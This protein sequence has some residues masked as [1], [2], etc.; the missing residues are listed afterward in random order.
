[1]NRILLMLLSCLSAIACNISDSEDELIVFPKTE[2]IAVSW[3]V[4]DDALEDDDRRTSQFSIQVNGDQSLPS[5]GWSLYFNQFPHAIYLSPSQEKLFQVENINGDLYR[6]LPSDSFPRVESGEVVQLGYKSHWPLVKK[7][8]GP[9]GVFFVVQ[10]GTP[11]ERVVSVINFEILPFPSQITYSTSRGKIPVHHSADIRYDMNQG[12]SD[13]PLA[14]VNRIVPTPFRSRS[15]GTVVNVKS[16]MKI[17]F[18]QGLEREADHLATF[19][20]QVLQD[21]ISS[22]DSETKDTGV[23]YL[24]QSSLT[25][26]G[27]SEEAYRLILHPSTGIEI[28]G[29]DPSGVFYGIQTFKA[30]LPVDAFKEPA[31]SIDVPAMTIEDIPRFGY[32]GLH[33]DI[34]RNFQDY[35]QIRKVIQLMAFYKLNRLHLHLTDDEGWRL[36]IPGLPEL[37]EVGSRRGWSTKESPVLPPAYGSGAIVDGEE[38]SGSGHLSREQFIQLLR[39]ANDHH[40]QIIPEING[41]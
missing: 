27:K 15:T 24:R 31:A 25:I 33:L 26:D 29:A 1:M 40:I 10:E 30:L 3:K 39:Y 16:N 37:T 21:P 6:I 17:L 23:I 11:H 19:L 41:P 12:I 18:D 20:N 14:K 2:Q 9:K 4:I 36:E 32:R 5:G 7:T 35:D 38:N 13:I 8:H 34:A 28:T 22:S